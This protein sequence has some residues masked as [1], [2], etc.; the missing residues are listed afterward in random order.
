MNSPVIRLLPSRRGGIRKVLLISVVVLLVL[1]G[2]GFFMVPGLAA[3]FVEGDHPLDAGG[4]KVYT[5]SIRDVS[6]SWFGGQKV[7]GVQ[8]K[9]QSGVVMADLKADGLDDDERRVR[10]ALL[11]RLPAGG[12][13]G[14]GG[15]RAAVAGGRPGGR[16]HPDPTRL[17]ESPPLR[18]DGGWILEP[19][20]VQRLGEPGVGRREHVGVDRP[21]SHV[22]H[23]L[24]ALK[25][26]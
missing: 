25:R 4:G 10:V 12:G 9:D 8:V 11:D 24:P 1:V 2:V 5:A 3:G 16:H 23:R 14:I 22:P 7:G 15:W 17:E 26:P 13:R 6:L 18:F 19:G 21:L 20:F